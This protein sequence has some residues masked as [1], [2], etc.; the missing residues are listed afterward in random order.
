MTLLPVLR[1]HAAAAE[2]RQ[3]AVRVHL[4]GL[5]P[6]N[7]QIGLHSLA[8]VLGLHNPVF[9][10]LTAPDKRYICG[11]AENC[12][13]LPVGPLWEGS[14]PPI[15]GSELRLSN[16]PTIPHHATYIDL[17]QLCSTSAVQLCNFNISLRIV[18]PLQRPSASS[19]STVLF[20]F[21]RSL[22]LSFLAVF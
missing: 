3:S 11:A 16:R 20:C 10:P 18:V 12:F 8:A 6:L 14:Q 19:P 13:S 9:S 7:T 4:D 5:A 17:V 22:C 15:V 2:R 21:S 1:N